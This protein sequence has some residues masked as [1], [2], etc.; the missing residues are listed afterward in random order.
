MQPVST[1]PSFRAQPN[2]PDNPPPL[3]NPAPPNPAPLNSIPGTTGNDSITGDS[4]NNFILGSAGNDTIN[5]AEGSDT[6][7][8]LS[9]PGGI[10][11]KA[12]GTVSKGAFGNDLLQNIETIIAP[13]GQ[14][15]TIDA[16]TGSGAAS[17]N[18][19]LS[20]NLVAVNN[21]PG[22]G[23]LNFTVENFD[24]VIGTANQD[25]ITGDRDNNY[26]VGEAGNDT[27]NGYG[28][29]DT[30][31]GVSASGLLQGSTEND[32]LL[33]GQ[34]QD[35]FVLGDVTST[36]YNGSGFASIGDFEAGIDRIQL[37]GNRS[38]Y[39][40]VG[41]SLFLATSN[42]LIATIQGNLN[43]GSFIFV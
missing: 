27:L 1:N 40:V 12:E 2:Q 22:I 23:T 24:N 21:V 11:I 30:L 25:V 3:P 18:I 39:R 15:N 34:G 36:F 38:D 19:D 5:G 16:S 41:D 9:L 20:A 32:V 14:T 31:I 10:T 7:S 8:Y 17:V 4:G 42:D 37:Y 28:G 43:P 29:N 33:G 13:L 6:I 35:L 26:L